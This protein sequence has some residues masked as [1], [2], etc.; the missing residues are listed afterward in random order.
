MLSSALYVDCRQ[1]EPVLVR[2]TEKEIRYVRS[3]ERV[4]PLT[5]RDRHANQQ[6]V[7]PA[8]T[9]DRADV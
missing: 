9:G 2:F 3:D 4:K 7:H 1:V 6:R 8:L 5:S